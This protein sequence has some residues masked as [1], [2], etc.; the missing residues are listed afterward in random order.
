LRRSRSKEKTLAWVSS[1]LERGT[2][3]VRRFPFSE[4]SSL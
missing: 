2:L 4:L 3:G 1:Q